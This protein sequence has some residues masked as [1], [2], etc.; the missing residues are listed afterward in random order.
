MNI[1]AWLRGLGLERYEQAFREN[2]VDAE[3]LPELTESDLASLGLPLGPRRKLLKAIARPRQ[4]VLPPSPTTQPSEVSR[5]GLG[6]RLRTRAPPADGDV[7]RSGWFDGA[8]G[9]ARS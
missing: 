8:L 2:E 5:P 1:G 6:A 4:G 3:A 7:L 9:A